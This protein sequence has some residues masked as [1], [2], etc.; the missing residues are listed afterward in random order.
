[1]KPSRTIATLLLSI[2]A[3][4]AQDVRVNGGAV[5]YVV[6]QSTNTNP[7]LSDRT[8]VIGYSQPGPYYGIGVEG[9]GG[10]VGVRGYSTI[11]GTGARYGGYF[12]GSNGTSGN[13]GVYAAA[14]GNN[15]NATN[16]GVYGSASSGSGGAKANYGVYCNGNGVYTGS[17]TKLSDLRTKKNIKSYTGSLEKIMSVG[18]KKYDFD[19][20]TYASMNLKSKPEVGIIA[21]EIEKIFPDIVEDIVAPSNN[22]DKNSTEVPTILKGVDY[23]ALVPILLQGMQEQQ[24]QINGLK[25][26]ILALKK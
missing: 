7:A 23:I 4:F 16:Y 18:V 10:F 11:T 24:V 17:W 22:T 13:Y 25:A 20:S 5:N 15:S 12:S 6:F 19:R 9:T 21:Q 3:C 2:S 1:M 26:Q 8:G 14:Y